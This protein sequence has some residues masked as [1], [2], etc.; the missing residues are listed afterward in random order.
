LGI[1]ILSSRS[2]AA[3]TLFGCL[4]GGGCEC[5]DTVVREVR[6]PDEK[7]KVVVFERSCGPTTGF[8]TQ[9]S[10]LPNDQS[11]P[12]DS[13]GNVFAADDN[14]HAVPVP[15]KGTMEVK[16]TWESNSSISI[17][18]PSKAQVFAKN[19][20]QAGVTIKYQAVP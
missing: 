9:I 6:S 12:S 11:L 7:L 17:A 20:N 4:L 18:Y 3:F 10:V 5:V 13:V 1:E 15:N 14:N 8:S 16:V 19:T 2:F